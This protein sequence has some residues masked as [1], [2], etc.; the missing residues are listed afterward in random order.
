MGDLIKRLALA[1]A[2]A[3]SPGCMDAP[4][5]LDTVMQPKYS[6]ALTAHNPRTLRFIESE[7]IVHYTFTLEK[8]KDGTLFSAALVHLDHNHGDRPSLL[9]LGQTYHYS[10]RDGFY[11]PADL[12]YANSHPDIHQLQVTNI[13]GHL[14]SHT[15]DDEVEFL[16]TK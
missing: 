6:V 9:Y 5:S 8:T 16:V 2:I 10:E 1:A 11:Y 15:L 4:D 7:Q 14:T 13:T 12:E 3:L